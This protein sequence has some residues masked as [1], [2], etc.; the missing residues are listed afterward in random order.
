MGQSRKKIVI[1]GASGFLGSVLLE[2]AAASWQT[3]GIFH[4]HPIPTSPQVRTVRLDLT[5]RQA[6][7]DFLTAEKPDVVLH[8][9]AQT[10]VDVCEKNPAVCQDINENATRHLSE[11]AASVGSRLIFISTDLVFDGKRGW[12]TEDD[13][14][15]PLSKYAQTKRVGEEIVQAACPNSVVARI[16]ILYGKS[17]QHRYSFSEWLRQSWEK[18]E[19]TPLFYDQF[20]TPIWVENLAE[21][22]LELAESSFTGILHLAGSQRIDRLSFAKIMARIL[23]VDERL[24]MPKSMFEIPSTAPR[25]QDV[26]LKIDRVRSLLK[27]PFLSV[28]E[29]LRRAYSTEPGKSFS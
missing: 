26:S 12:Y 17:P 10:R 20:R 18:G 24:L 14:T 22:L 4:T 11:A 16:A 9:A 6:V 27:T 29:G 8:T 13:A 5:A 1:T 23:G 19:P 2:R 21:A 7:F 15:N 25:P 3:V 28:E